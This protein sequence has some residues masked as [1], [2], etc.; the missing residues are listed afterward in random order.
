MT[1]HDAGLSGSSIAVPVAF[2][3]AGAIVRPIDAEPDEEYRCPGCNSPL[4]LRRGEMR[5]AHFA[6]RRGDGCSPDS[7]LHRAAKRRVVQVIE[8]WKDGSGPRPSVARPCPSV[9]CDG[10][11]TQ[12]LPDDVTHAREEVRL[13]DGSVADVV[14]FRGDEHA[15]AVE[16][17]VTHRVGPDK[18][19]R[20]P[21]PWLELRADDVLERPYWWVAIQDALAPFTC[22]A[23]AR[24]DG[25]RNRSIGEVEDRARLIAQRLATP[26]PPS[27]PYR[28]VPHDCWR[29][30]SEM[31][32]FLWPGAGSQSAR[33]PPEPIPASVQHRVTDGEGDYWA[34]C[35]P[36]CST[37]Q[38]EYYLERD[39]VDYLMVRENA[40][41][42]LVYPSAWLTDEG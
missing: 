42:L 11:I 34:N 36:A 2:S 10:G 6:H 12:D 40:P 39:N 29:C 16:I 24:L 15:A 1:K 37:I 4:L 31:V 13:A 9:D 30:G 3:S 38:G 19:A 18:A 27:P 33:P 41:D 17:L 20:M 22:P 35:C 8:A 23:C 26:L 25:A 5:R 32:A 28:Y 14:L 7:Q 21:L